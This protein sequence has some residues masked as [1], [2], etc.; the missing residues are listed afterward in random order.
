MILKNRDM[1][2][3][4]SEKIINS[5]QRLGDERETLELDLDK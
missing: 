3:Y 1:F 4:I 5:S 2:R